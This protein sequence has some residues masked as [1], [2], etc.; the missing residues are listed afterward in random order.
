MI[1]LSQPAGAGENLLTVQSWAWRGRKLM[2]DNAERRSVYDWFNRYWPNLLL[3]ALFIAYIWY[4]H[5]SDP[6]GEEDNTVTIPITITTDDLA[7]IKRRETTDAKLIQRLVESIADGIE[8]EES[9][10]ES[11]DPR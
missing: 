4:L 5:L 9:E 8:A 10:G 7:S 2:D 1:V 6:P 11:Y 3:A